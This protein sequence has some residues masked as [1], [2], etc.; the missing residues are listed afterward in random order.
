MNFS[1][2]RCFVE[3]FPMCLRCA[4][5]WRGRARLA[6]MSGVVLAACWALFLVSA[7]SASAAG[8]IALVMAAEDYEKFQK[9]SVGVNRG[10]EIADALTARG[11]EVILSANP[12]NAGARAKLR[13]FSDKAEGADL[14]VAV[15]IGHGTALGGQSFFL[16]INAEIGRATDLLSRALSVT[17]VAQI[18]GRAKNGGVFFFM[19]SPNF[20]TPVEGLDARPQFNSE[21]GK[22]I[23][24][25]F[26]SSSRVPL[27]R[28]DA[29]SHQAAEAF[30]KLLQQPA[31]SFG[32]AA[33]TAASGN[34]GLVVGSAADLSLAKPPPAPPAEQVAAAA[35]SNAE[36]ERRTEVEKRLEAERLAR[37]LAEKQARAE[38]IKTEQAQAEVQKAQADARKAQA[39]AERAQADARKA[40]AEAE[41]AQAEAERVKLEAKR[42]EAQAQ[43][44]NAR[45]ED[46]RPSNVLLVEDS[47]LGH[48]QRQLIQE[49][50]R[51][52]GLYTGAIDSIM[53]PLTRE[54]IMGYQKSRRAPVTGYLTADQFDA[55][56]SR[57][58]PTP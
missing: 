28:I 19:T 13:D 14:A 57:D 23:V 6:G 30:A 25:V 18:V 49:R 5:G 41:R 50:L 52:L 38:Q 40:Q 54:A 15:L 4:S 17:N 21:I 24:A 11:F 16:P 35:R 43:F 2:V 46:S 53:G 27:S 3:R 47:Q 22:N 45:P 55:L 48:K 51:E 32:E 8:R 31:P 10:K 12:S 36:A 44:A 39:D 26:S 1:E 33:K 7:A 9:S 29:T 34:L 37:E 58:K 20:D 56:L 42:V